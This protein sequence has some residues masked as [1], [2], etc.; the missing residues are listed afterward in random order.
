MHCVCCLPHEHQP[1]GVLDKVVRLS[2]VK[3][4][5]KYT[6]FWLVEHAANLPVDASELCTAPEVVHARHLFG[7]YGSHEIGVRHQLFDA[8]L[9]QNKPEPL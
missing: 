1:S 3:A 2:K 5:L 4:Q 7:P 6:M 9:R 8:V